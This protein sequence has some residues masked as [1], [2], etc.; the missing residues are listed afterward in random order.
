MN[1]VKAQEYAASLPLAELKKYADGFN[2]AMIPPWLATGE[3]QAKMKRAEMAN[4]LQGAAQ[5]PMPSVKEQVEQKAGIMAL[6]QAQ[7]Q[8]A[9]Q[10]PLPAAGPVPDGTPQPRPQAQTPGLDQL[11]S[12]I[13]MAG[14][15]IV[16]FA[17]GDKVTGKD[18]DEDLPLYARAWKAQRAAEAAKK[19]AAL[20]A[21][22]AKN[23]ALVAGADDNLRP[24]MANDPRLLQAPAEETVTPPSPAPVPAP[25]GL[26]AAAQKPNIPR[27]VGGPAT[28][29]APASDSLETLFRKS[30]EG[31]P[32]E[33]SVQDQLAEQ[34]AIRA[35]AG[36]TEPAGKAQLERIAALDKQYAATKPTGL[37]ELI[38]MFGQSGQYKGL[39]GLAPAYTNIEA[40]KR[41]ADLAHAKAINEMMSGVETTQRGEKTQLAKDVTAG[42]EKDLDRTSTFGREKM[43]T[44]G[45][46]AGSRYNA[47][48]HYKAAMA[49]IGAADKRADMTEKRDLINSFK[50]RIAAID[51][52]LVPLEKSLM[53]K[54]RELAAGY[55]AEKAGLTKALDEASGIS[56][57]TGAPSAA[58]PSGTSTSGWGKAQVVK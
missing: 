1:L 41:A 56:K 42:R 57:I 50:V 17:T 46:A 24:T 12:N 32:K 21:E 3:M 25:A 58:S 28:S 11:P 20:D 30:L 37:Q 43:Q 10:Q 6:Q 39:S 5:G 40:Q 55:R 48:M 23:M 18:D 45:Q 19:R 7:Q 54:D 16:A 14:G 22:R 35:G 8:Q 4:N 51:R 53:P 49:Q 52:E 2:P 29:A 9:A 44:L 26:A 13:Q 36:L 27:P 34:N 38:Q 31:G 33:R 47:D 15:G